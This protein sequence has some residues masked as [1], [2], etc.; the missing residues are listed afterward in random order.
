[1]Y[2]GYDGCYCDYTGCTVAIMD[3]IVTILWMYCG[4]NGCYCDYTRCAMAILDDIVNIL[5]VLWLY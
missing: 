2:S 5:D 1:M 4:Y 3:V